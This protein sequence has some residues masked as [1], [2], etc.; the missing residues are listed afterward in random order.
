MSYPLRDWFRPQP[1]M[2]FRREMDRLLGDVFAPAS[3]AF[4]R[5]AVGGYPS[6]NVWEEDDLL[7]AE[8][9]VAGMKS[10]ELD[11]SVVGNQLTIKGSRTSA[12]PEGGTF[13]RRERSVGEF[14]RVVTLPVEIDAEKVEANL[15][16]GVL[17]I[18]L[19]KA[20]AAKPRKVTVQRS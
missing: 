6:L 16:D 8:A 15:V 12:A 5:L 17:T 14:T 1:V 19:P 3:A 10:E 7:Y 9:E 20:E 18:K 13:H 4:E 11:I 2:N